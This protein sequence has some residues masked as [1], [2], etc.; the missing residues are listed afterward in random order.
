[1]H[2]S[3]GV[4]FLLSLTNSVDHGK[5][6]YVAFYLGLHCLQ[7]GFPVYKEQKFRLSGPRQTAA[8]QQDIRRKHTPVIIV[9]VY[10]FEILN[11]KTFETK[12]LFQ[13]VPLTGAILTFTILQPGKHQVSVSFQ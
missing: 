1:M 8:Y 2:I 5:T 7:K 3:W 12:D 6:Y 9:M 13:L 10:H 4:R 11:S